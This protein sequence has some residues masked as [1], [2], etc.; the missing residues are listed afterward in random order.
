MFGLKLG[1]ESARETSKLLLQSRW[2]RRNSVCIQAHAASLVYA[3]EKALQL[4][5]HISWRFLL[6]LIKDVQFRSSQQ[7]AI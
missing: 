5:P 2:G 6:I 3:L 1:Q 4:S 7:E